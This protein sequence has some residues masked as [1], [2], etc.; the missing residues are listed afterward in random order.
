MPPIKNLDEREPII[1][2][3][4]TVQAD[5]NTLQPEW[6]AVKP[7]L[8]LGTILLH[9]P[10]F[11]YVGRN[12][13][14][15]EVT[16]PA[17][18]ALADMDGTHTCQELSLSH[19]IPL[20]DIHTLVSELDRASLID[21]HS[22]KISV[23]T[24]FHSPN[25]NRTSHDGDD[26]NDGAYQQLKARLVPELSSTTWIAGVRD[27][28]ALVV[29]KRQEWKVRICGESR[30]ATLLYGILL[31]SGVTNTT[32]QA[33]SNSKRIGQ[34]D[35]CAGFLHPSDIGLPLEKRLSEITR[36]LSLFPT[37]TTSKPE[38]GTKPLMVAVG[39]V[40]ADQIQKWMSQGIPHLIIGVPECESIEIGPIVIPGQSPCARC[41]AMTREDQNPTW[42][43]IALQKALIPRPEVPVAVAHH[44]AGIAAL[45]LLHFFDEGQSPLVG[46]SS[47]INFHGP[48]ASV[49]QTF[50][51]HPA[52]GCNW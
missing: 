40:S 15:L 41:I 19:E 17:R 32:L 4:N 18:T 27:G 2:A 1:S 11:T 52:C 42:R 50:A 21:T 28:G 9:G 7:H 13:R 43:E 39:T 51:R 46:A 3:M 12:D 49:M 16:P 30:I 34:E 8:K 23:H 6:C 44:V 26:S 35:L 20:D 29:S 37:G 33:L 10:E 47:R 24:R 14:G 25:I 48:L 38:D 22:S 45:E 5:L 36:E 31:A